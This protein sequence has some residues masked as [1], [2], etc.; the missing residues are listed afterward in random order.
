MSRIG[1]DIVA[2]V[3]GAHQDAATAGEERK[4]RKRSADALAQVPLLSALSRRHLHQLADVSQIT[5][6][7][8]GT[9]VIREGDLGSTLYVIVEGQAV[10][11]RGGKRL[12]TL[13]PGDFFGEVSLLDGGPRTASVTAETRLSVVRLFRR[14]FYELVRTEPAIGVKVLSELAKRV[15]RVDRAVRG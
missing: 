11:S 5:A 2:A 14:P 10:V 1:T 8:Q 9:S 13:A 4:R 7:R 6:Y 3:S 12:T 15:R